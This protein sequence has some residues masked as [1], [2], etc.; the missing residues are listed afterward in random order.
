MIRLWDCSAY[1]V[2]HELNDRA[3]EQPLWHNCS[4]PDSVLRSVPIG[5]GTEMLLCLNCLVGINTFV[6]RRSCSVGHIW[7]LVGSQGLQAHG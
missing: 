5:A 2:V 1:V 4:D 3:N 7:L 6:V